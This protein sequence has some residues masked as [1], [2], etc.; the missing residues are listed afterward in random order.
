MIKFGIPFSKLNN[1]TY[2]AEENSLCDKSFGI[3]PTLR[4]S[5]EGKFFTTTIFHNPINPILSNIWPSEERVC[6]VTSSTNITKQTFFRDKRETCQGG[7]R[8]EIGN[9]KHHTKCQKTL[10]VMKVLPV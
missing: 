7:K 9:V 4:M 2:R 3:F 1:L 10:D 5:S 8:C 6:K